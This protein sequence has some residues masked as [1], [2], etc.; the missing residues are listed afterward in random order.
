[1]RVTTMLNALAK[2]ADRAGWYRQA[3]L[4][5]A[6]DQL[7]EICRRAKKHQD[8]TDKLHARLAARLAGECVWEYTEPY[9]WTE[10]GST[11]WPIECNRKPAE[12]RYCP[13][14]GRRIVVKED[15]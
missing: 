8:W 4:G 5:C 2:A 9:W 13:F 10:C 11:S 14:C 7:A 6:E 15:A 1:M 3:V 12:W